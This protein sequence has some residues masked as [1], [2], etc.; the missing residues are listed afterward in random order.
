MP[1]S[2]LV[3]RLVAFERYLFIVLFIYLLIMLLRSVGC[4][5]LGQRLLRLRAQLAAEPAACLQAAQH[6]TAAEAAGP[7]SNNAQ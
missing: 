6:G 5:L 4:A 7:H 3:L 2:A 1:L